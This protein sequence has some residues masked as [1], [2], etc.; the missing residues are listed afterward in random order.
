MF[1]SNNSQQIAYICV[2][3]GLHSMPIAIVRKLP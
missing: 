1:K 2:P 3:A